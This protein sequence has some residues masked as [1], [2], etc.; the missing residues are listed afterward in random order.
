VPNYESF[1]WYGLL[2]PAK[3][4]QR[5][6]VILEKATGAVLGQAEVQQRLH[7][8]GVDLPDVGQKEFARFLKV[9]M[10]RWSEVIRRANLASN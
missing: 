7:G 6:T 1:P 9:E 10:Q 5:I 3:T 2:A 4:P 8:L